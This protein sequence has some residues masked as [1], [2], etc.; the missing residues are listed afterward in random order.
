[1]IQV[2]DQLT[3]NISDAGYVS[4]YGIP[5]TDLETSGLGQFKSLGR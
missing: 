3:G 4:Y 1:M 2:I 5:Q